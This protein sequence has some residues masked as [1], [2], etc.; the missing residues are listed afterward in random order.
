LDRPRRAADQPSEPTPQQTVAETTPQPAEW[1]GQEAALSAVISRLDGAQ[2][3]AEIQSGAASDD[4]APTALARPQ[5]RPEPAEV[6]AR[7]AD[8]PE[9]PKAGDQPAPRF[10]LSVDS[11]ETRTMPP[12]K[13]AVRDQEAHFEPVQQPTLLQKIVDRMGADLPAAATPS[14]APSTEAGLPDVL[15]AADGPVKI[16]TLQ[17]DPPDLGAVT[18]KMRLTG[19]A[20][21]VRLSADSYETTR[22]LQGERKALTDLMQSAG[23]KFDIAAIDHSRASDANGGAGQQPAQSEQRLSPPANGGSQINDGISER[24]SGDAQ[25]GTRQNRQQHEQ[26]TG[27]AEPRQDKEVVRHR[28]GGAVYL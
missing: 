13:V 10:A 23:Y 20:V 21:E 17:L 2:A 26:F 24:Q 8:P 4:V 14:G 27:R 1:R 25:A 9:S 19:D 12:V 18:V 15:K 3:H 16:L 6:A 5:S 7:P 28:N 22:L 11:I